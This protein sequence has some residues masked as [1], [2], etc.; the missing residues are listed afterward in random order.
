MSRAVFIKA[1][2]P[3][4]EGKGA[5]LASQIQAIRTAEF[6][7]DDVF[8]RDPDSFAAIPTSPFAYWV[9]E[10]IRQIFEEFPPLEGNAGTVKQGLATADD[11]RFLRAWWE[12]D[13]ERIGYSAKDSAQGKG[14]I[15]FAKGGSYSPYYA[16]VHL[17]V[18]WFG[19]GVEVRSFDRAFIRNE[20][21]YFRPGLTWPLRSQAGLSVR[22]LPTGCVFGH[23]GPSILPDA[24]PI[25]L[26]LL[27]ITNSSSFARLVEAQMAFGSYEVGVLQRTPVPDRAT[28]ETMSTRNIQEMFETRR[29]PAVFDETTHEF[30]GPSL[31]GL[32]GPLRTDCETRV[33]EERARWRHEQVLSS[34]IDVEVASLFGLKAEHA[35]KTASDATERDGDEDD[36]EDMDTFVEVDASS[37]VANLLSWIVGVVVGRWDVRAASTAP[38]CDLPGP[39]D[40]LPRQAPGT[41]VTANGQAAKATEIA[42]QAWLHARRNSLHSPAPD[43][44]DG[45]AS[46]T[47]ANYPVDVT[48]DGILVDDPD[49]PKD[50]VRKVR[51]V[52]RQIYGD[53]AQEIEEE[54]VSILRGAGRT[55]RTLR[56][57]FRNQ[58]AT[59]LGASFFDF[60]IKRYSKSRR[61]APIYWRL[62]G[63]PGRGQSSYGIWLYYHR[64]TEDSLWKVLREYVTPRRELEERR[65]EEARRKL[66]AAK[67]SEARKLE[68]EIDERTEFLDEIGWFEDEVRRVAQSGWAPNRDDGV[69][70]NLAPLYKL[71]PWSEPEQVWAKLE[72]EEFDWAHLAMRYWPDRVTEKCRSDKSLAL[73]HDLL[74]LY[75]GEQ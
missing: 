17:V 52:L 35:S 41:L 47:A 5:Y 71:V 16:D 19:R 29:H 37:R 50:V 72:A 45:P 62:C 66:P 53:H 4:A 38:E 60:H 24:T 49:H 43:E 65:L 21:H 8:F 12:I 63:R 9:S 40:P 23:K 74:D 68:S 70:V 48:W 57:W 30:F 10:T 32:R 25:Y 2:E 61:K 13:P 1:L 58:K 46:I 36:D 27:A 20:A 42:S 54:A 44:F 6:E 39:F 11:F 14:W 69:I 33:E 51:E 75:Q 67:G 64:L 28:L 34:K 56:D 31:G 15:H 59:D 55:P 7:P 18:N 73:A 26:P 22:G 3:E